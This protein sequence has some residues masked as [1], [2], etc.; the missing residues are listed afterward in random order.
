MKIII[1][2][3]TYLLVYL[4][5]GI[6]VMSSN[7]INSRSI[8][9]SVLKPI[10]IFHNAI[11]LVKNDGIDGFFKEFRHPFV[12]D[13]YR[14][15]VIN[16]LT[17]D[18]FIAKVDLNYKIVV[19]NLKTDSI[20][21]TIDIKNFLV[22][23]DLE[24]HY[25][26]KLARINS[27]KWAFMIENG[28]YLYQYSVATNELIKTRLPGFSHHAI[29]V[30]NEKV[31]VMT[32]KNINRLTEY[33]NPL[34]ENPSDSI[35]DQGYVVVNQE[36]NI[37]EE[38][39]ISNHI[40]ELDSAV[41]L[42]SIVS[43]TWQSND[44]FHLNDVEV[45]I[46]DSCNGQ[47]KNGDILLSSRNTSSLIHVRDKRIINC[48]TGDWNFQHD[49][50]VLDC[51]RLSIFDNNSAGCYVGI[52]SPQ[53]RLGVL[54]FSR[55]ILSESYMYDDGTIS[56]TNQGKVTRIGDLT[57]VENQNQNNYLI[58]QKSK[59][60]YRSPYWYDKELGLVLRPT[61]DVFFVAEFN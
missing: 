41:N 19:K 12:R 34:D 42:N 26:I 9:Y 58:F 14:D 40:D 33:S 11:T 23:K 20:V 46:L 6:L 50:D 22:P 51:N 21:N 59:L 15:D 57:I 27:S 31:V 32:A 17:Q 7:E 2:L 18:V 56:S 24:D 3:S 47:F 28:F 5:T 52:K 8:V 13:Y 38:F 55:D 44:P 4:L 49:V 60:I 1:R 16:L 48:Y 25:P 29:E 45:V 54:D 36:G 39:W 53:S 30:F 10:Q 43:H 37:E 35:S 61:W